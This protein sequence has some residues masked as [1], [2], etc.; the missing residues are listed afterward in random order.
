MNLG[1]TPQEVLDNPFA[2][3]LAP[4]W[5]QAIDMIAEGLGCEVISYDRTHD[6]LL[7]NQDIDTAVGIIEKDT[8]GLNHF[9]YIGKTK[10]GVE[11]IQEQI[12]YVDDIEQNRLQGGCL[13]K[14]TGEVDLTIAATWFASNSTSS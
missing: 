11:T 8:I 4:S 5:N 10:E 7:A 3:I 12:W 14:A 2:A 6:Y 13:G 9:R 1:K